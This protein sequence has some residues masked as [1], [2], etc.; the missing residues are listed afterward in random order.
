MSRLDI[1]AAEWMRL[2]RLLDEALDREPDE[3]VAWI[4]SLGPEHEFL[5][6]QLRDLLSRAGSIETGDFL[7]TLPG[8]LADSA[9]AD[10]RV[11][12]AGEVVGPYRLVRELGSGGMGSVWLAERA[13]GLIHR[14]V[15][16]KLPH[17]VIARRAELAERMAREREILATL[18]HRNI[19]RLFDAGITAE[20]QPYL[21]LEFVEGLPIDE[22]C[23][24][25][26]QRPPL[27]LRA[28][29][30]LFRQVAEAV[31]YAHGK[32][33]V[34]R[35]LKPANILVTAN[36]GARLL[37]FGIAKLLDEGQTRETRLTQAAGR[38]LTPDYA[39]PE[40]ILGEPLTVASD[41]Y[42]LGVILYELLSGERPYKLKRDSRGALEDAI[43]QGEPRRPSEAAPL[44]LRRALR[45]DLD[46]ITLK[47]LKKRPQD[48][49]ATV[50]ALA[51][52]I[53]RH[54]EH[55][56]VL[57]Q[58]DSTW[59]RLRKFVARNKLGVGAASV[60]LL[61]VLAGAGAAMWQ[62]RV[63]MAE[64][65]RAEAIRGF[66]SSV[67][68]EADPYRQYG[69]PLT[70]AELLNRARDRVGDQFTA[71]PSLRTELTAMIG[72]SL[73]GLGELEAAES[74]ARAAEADAS[75]TY[76]PDQVETLRARVLLAEVHAARRDNAALGKDVEELVPRTRALAAA[77]PDLLVRML[78]ASA[79]LAIE[80]TRYADA[81]APAGEAFRL[82]SAR[83]G[84]HHS[85]TVAASTLYVEA[86]LFAN[87]PVEPLVAEARRGMDLALEAGGG[88]ADNPRVI[89]MRDVYVRVLSRTGDLR[90]TV[91][92][93]DA[94][95]EATQRTF[96]A[97]S[98][99]AARAMLNTVRDY[100]KVGQIDN[101]LR[102]SEHALRILGAGIAPESNEYMFAVSSHALMLIAARR[103][104]AAL[105]RVAAIEEASR[106]QSGATHWNTVSLMLQH[107]H[108]L[109]RLGRSREAAALLAESWAAG[110]PHEH[111]SWALRMD[112]IVQRLA[113]NHGAALEKLSESRR[114][115]GAS[116]H[117][118]EKYRLALETGLT[119]VE[120]GDAG[121]AAE[122][123]TV[124]TIFERLGMAM[125]PAYA[126][127]L[128]GQGRTRMLSNDAA[129]AVGLFERALAFWRKF[130]AG[131]AATAD[132]AAWLERARRAS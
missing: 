24:G 72:A 73:L 100:S 81:L 103:F 65:D 18:D 66:I 64:R 94:L 129:G 77:H 86:L 79:D 119:L 27:N 41:V 44:P 47:A 17:R 128:V 11:G 48:R 91:R 54:L 80:E 112:A 74:A 58:P 70:A 125:H 113:G 6:P 23:R 60:V 61:A 22:Y 111:R 132:A 120:L 8:I 2:S 35:D 20:G 106:R 51:D 19:A 98:L 108:V 123:G 102:N 43:V 40:Q 96:G 92:E 89:Q 118:D 63:A 69:R 33:V 1:D 56:P 45:G 9:A 50:N 12:L 122:F 95:I 67:F 13:D 15:A 110:V 29:L 34:H 114:L 75:L 78:K 25:N 59:Y 130:D 4:D 38:A 126:E 104:D 116:A 31:A 87:G 16:L 109:A 10:E 82:A 5:K 76:G 21:A 32:L 90:A 37:D 97:D 84:A 121:A 49:Y 127:M 46:T 101:A 62:A 53:T 115:S 93:A 28:R 131:N 14:H 124:Q 42:S 39:S 99:A 68:E 30:A 71:D 26:A 7:A 117:D 88:H 57:A 107:A 105:P 52:D 85:V 36:G 83:L 55:R 3:R